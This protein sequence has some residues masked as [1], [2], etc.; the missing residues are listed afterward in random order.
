M[1]SITCAPVSAADAS[2]WFFAY[3]IE[4]ERRHIDRHGLCES[5]KSD[6]FVRQKE[7][8]QKKQIDGLLSIIWSYRMLY[9]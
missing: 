4:A 1:C 7:E 8:K 3:G 6:D 2:E 5:E 9:D